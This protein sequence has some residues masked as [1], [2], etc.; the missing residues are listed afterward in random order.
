[1]LHSSMSIRKII[2]R[3]K[4]QRTIRERCKKRHPM[5]TSKSSPKRKIFSPPSDQALKIS[6]YLKGSCHS[7]GKTSW[8]NSISARMSLS[9][10]EFKIDFKELSRWSSKSNNTCKNYNRL[11]LF[12]MISASSILRSLVKLAH[13]EVSQKQGLTRTSPSPNPWWTAIIAMMQV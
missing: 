8:R 4:S 7:T 9:E 2:R 13:R 12:K 5:T 11:S 6:C 3:G 1:M 10:E